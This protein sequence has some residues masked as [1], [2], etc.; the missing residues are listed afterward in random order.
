MDNIT[1]PIEIPTKKESVRTLEAIVKHA[2][3]VPAVQRGDLNLG[4]WVV[5][6]TRNSTYSIR[7][8]GNN[9][10]SVSGGWFDQRNLSPQ[11]IAVNGCTWGGTAIKNDIVAAPGLFLEFANRVKTTRIQEVKVLRHQDHGEVH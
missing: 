2:Q 9:L 1:Q 10:Y 11:R 6:T 8:L 3:G 7:V 4:D 5:V